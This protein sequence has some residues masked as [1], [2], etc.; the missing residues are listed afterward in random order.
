LARFGWK[1]L[2]IR[3]TA[4]STIADTA[5]DIDAM[6]TK[7]PL[8]LAMLSATTALMILAPSAFAASQTPL[9]LQM[10]GIITN[11]GKQTY[12]LSG[13]QIVSGL[14][15]SKPVP[16]SD[17]LN[18][19]LFSNVNGL[20]TSGFGSLTITNSSN[21]GG[22]G[23]TGGWGSN[24]RGDGHGSHSNTVLSGR[25]QIT[26]EVP[27]QVFP[28]T[29]SGVYPVSCT[30]NCNSQVPLLFT[31]SLILGGDGSGQSQSIPIAIESAYWSPFGGPIV[32]SS[33]DS[34]PSIF[35]VVTYRTATIAWAG[36]QLQGVLG[37]NYGS[38]SVTG[39]YTMT[40]YSF[41]NLVTANELD[42]GQISFT[43]MSDSSLNVGGFYHGSTTFST[44]GE[45][46]CSL[47]TSLPEGTCWFTG[48]SSSGSF[49]MFAHGL[50]I[51][52]SYSTNWSV[53]SLTTSSSV[54][55]TVTQH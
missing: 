46:D 34:P 9:T 5:S 18:F 43:G 48:A 25:I 7:K 55:A 6:K 38:E 39:G 22:Q 49:Q 27:A 50:G 31:G 13:G 4:K 53:P 2:F 14:V 23:D 1:F 45:Q 30:S 42:A 21:S 35:L 54:T 52:G 26:D 8:A 33:L 20:T 44:A 17:Q 29:F 15:F 24:D 11:A 28:V 36:V 16:S 12:F 37:G 3:K 10:Q 41:E 51:T 40:S 47:L 32:I 19:N